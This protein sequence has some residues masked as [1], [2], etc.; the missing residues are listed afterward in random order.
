MTI[1]ILPALAACTAIACTDEA[2]EATPAD[3][4]SQLVAQTSNPN[5]PGWRVYSSRDFNFDGSADVLWHNFEKDLFTVWLMRGTELLAPGPVI[6]G[7]PGVG[8]RAM[9]AGDFNHD[10]MAD[11][12]WHNQRTNEMSVWLMSGTAL[13]A[14]GPPIPGPPGD[15]WLLS[16]RVEDMNFDGMFDVIWNNPKTNVA[17]VWLMSGTAVLAEGPDLIG[18]PGDGWRVVEPADVNHDGMGDIVWDDPDRNLMTVWLM[19][20]TTVLA[21]GPVLPGPPEG[22]IIIPSTGDFNFDGMADVQWTNVKLKTGRV[23]LMNGTTRLAQGPLIQ[24]PPGD[25]WAAGS[26]GDFNFDAMQD[27]LWQA[28]DPPRLVVYLMNG[29]TPIAVGP[30]IASP[31]P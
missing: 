13:L 10:G 21:E 26:N 5:S 14:P 4:E 22:G 29:T 30:V 9:T 28:A 27:L 2:G 18:P 20:G 23:W 19:H 25:G 24:G 3:A 16:R 8:W 1:R 15:G 17:Q 6:P 7:P 12:L 31:L 11:V